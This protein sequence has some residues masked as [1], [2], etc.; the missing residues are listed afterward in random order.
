[1]RKAL[2]VGIDYYEH[3]N[4][5]R[6]CVND[7][8]AVRAV[9]ERHAD[10]TPNF[11]TPYLLTASTPGQ[12]ITKGKLK[13]AVKELFKGDSDIAL[14]YFSGHGFV[15]E[16]GGFLCTSECD[17]G[18]DGLALSELMSLANGSKAKNTVI[19]LDSCH[20]GAAGADS[21]TSVFA[22]LREGMTIL[23][24]ST[25]DQYAMES[26]GSGL[27][28]S[29][30]VDAL[31]GGAANLLGEVTP[32]SVY[33]H[34]DQSLG[35]W[36]Q[37]PVFRTNVKSFIS[38]RK[39]LPPIALSDL[40]AL[41]KHFPSPG[42]VFPLDPAYEPERSAEDKANPN[43]PQP[44]PAK[45]AVFK[46]LQKYVRVNLVRPI[47]EEHMWHAAM[48]SKACGLTVLGEHYRKLVADGLI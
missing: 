27:F 20:S 8:N 35:P 7:A 9:L 33:A 11:V 13:D 41:S 45:N 21:D 16:T 12:A 26:G 18:D 24:A 1:M 42:Y 2:I 48:H 46:L 37:R 15:E 40:Q 30:L 39:A 29:L 23:T 25:A 19:L 32:G 22:K 34:I 17:R 31:S 4:G 44:D 36:K 10:G 38:L 43:I 47:G 6:G 5:L 14:F 28:T 3:I